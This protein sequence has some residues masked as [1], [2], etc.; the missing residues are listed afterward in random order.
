MSITGV[1]GVSPASLAQT[2]QT[3]AA[4]ANATAQASLT[5]QASKT[6]HLQHGGGDAPPHAGTAQTAAVTPDGTTG[7]DMFV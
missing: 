3:Q 1:S 2:P 5:Q 6:H 4:Q 7:V